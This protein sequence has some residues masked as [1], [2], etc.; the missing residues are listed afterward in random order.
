MREIFLCDVC[1]MEMKFK[2]RVP[3]KKP[4]RIRR[5]EC[6]GC[7]WQQTIFAGGTRDDPDKERSKVD[8]E[9]DMKVAEAKA[10]LTEEET[11]P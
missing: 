5:F 3:S 1:S 4:Y 10:K 11:E 2:E 9:L 7:G 6:P 8:F